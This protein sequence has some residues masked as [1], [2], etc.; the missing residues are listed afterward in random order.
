MAEDGRDEPCSDVGV[1]S[2][3]GKTSLPCPMGGWLPHTVS[4]QFRVAECDW[5]RVVFIL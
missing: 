3:D 2:S 1:E 4:S 5:G